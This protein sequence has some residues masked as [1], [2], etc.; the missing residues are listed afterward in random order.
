MNI[1]LKKIDLSKFYYNNL[2]RDYIF[3]FDKIKN[4]YQYDF[5]RIDSYK[6]RFE[7]ISL[8]Y[9]HSLRP[10]VCSILK[11]YNENLGCSRK[12]IENIDALEGS[13]SAVVIGG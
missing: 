5:R 11:K 8:N 1:E 3:N 7:D 6:K 13:K 2:H 4:Y 12:T 10:E 9:N